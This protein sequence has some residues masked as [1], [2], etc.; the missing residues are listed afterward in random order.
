M[1]KYNAALKDAYDAKRSSNVVP[2]SLKGKRPCKNVCLMYKG[3]PRY[4]AG[5]SRCTTCDTWVKWDGPN[6]PCCGIKLRKRGRSSLSKS[7]R[8]VDDIRA[9]WW[10]LEHGDGYYD[11]YHYNRYGERGGGVHKVWSGDA[12][13]ERI[14]RRTVPVERKPA[15][16]RVVGVPKHVNPYGDTPQRIFKFLLQEEKRWKEIVEYIGD[17]KSKGSYVSQVLSSLRYQGLLV[18]RQTPIGKMY[19]LTNKGYTMIFSRPP[20]ADTELWSGYSNR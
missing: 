5:G 6:C 2:G 14:S 17:T 11:N 19:G 7:A 10:W 15:K 16:P 9:G 20:E 13:A 12:R 8:T 3:P 1:R 18:S 4:G